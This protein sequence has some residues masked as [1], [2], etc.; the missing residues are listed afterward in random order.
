MKA[1]CAICLR[2]EL[3][4]GGCRCQ[5]F[6]LTGDATA[7]D[8]AC[9]LAPEHA[10]IEEFATLRTDAQKAYC[11]KRFYRQRHKIENCFCRAKDWRRIAM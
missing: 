11:P 7:T 4:F 3:D 8:P 1:P 10:R 9:H 5:A 2:R 6:A